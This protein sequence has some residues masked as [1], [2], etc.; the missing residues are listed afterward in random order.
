MFGD[1]HLGRA[2][3]LR[4]ERRGLAQVDLAA[5]IPVNKATMNTYEK[6]KRGMDEATLDRIAA[7]LKCQ[8]VD[9]WDDAYGIFRFNLLRKRAETMGTT[10]EE[11]VGRTRP[12]PTLDGIRTGFQAVAD[13]LWKMVADV[14]LFLRPD[15]A[16]GNQGSVSMWGVIVDTPRAS[17]KAIRFQRGKKGTSE[18]EPPSTED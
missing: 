6:G 10:A 13:N 15:R 4:R 3:A 7:V 18:P 5:A 1:E 16:D 9:L 14:L 8:T 12:I 2:V 17:S 11:L